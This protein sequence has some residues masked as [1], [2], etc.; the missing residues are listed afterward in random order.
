[1]SEKWKEILNKNTLPKI[2]KQKKQQSIERLRI[3]IANTEITVK[4]NYFEKIRRY[5]PFMNKTTFLIQFVLLLIGIFVIKS[6]AFEKTRL[7]LSLV[8][9]ILAF[10]Q[11]MELQKSF[12]YNMYEIEMSCKMNLKELI[13][14]KLIINTIIN[15]CVMTILAVVTGTHFEQES[16]VLILYF[17]VP[18]MI[19]N[20]ANIV[21]MRLLKHKSNEIV[22]MTIM[23]LINAILLIL[24]IKFPCVYEMSSIL[25]WIGLLCITVFYFTKAVYRFFE[26][27]DDY[28]WN[29]Q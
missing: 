21:T 18:F 16:Y 7:I 17:L 20:V 2:D 9:P 6:M 15:L 25:V 28:I 8:M 13:S 3:E 22:N 26:E 10:L 29:L 1:M 4:E 27:E 12:K 5:V 19:A 24:N 23:L 14:I 11:M